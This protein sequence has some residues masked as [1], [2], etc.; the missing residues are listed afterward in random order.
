VAKEKPKARTKPKAASAGSGIERGATEKEPLWWIQPRLRELA[1]PIGDVVLDARNAKTHDANSIDAI[2][3]SLSQFG[4]TSPITVQAEGMVV[5]AGNGR[6]QAAIAL[7]WTHIAAN[8]IGDKAAAWWNAFALAD[9]RS[10]ELAEWNP[11]RVDELLRECDSGSEELQA[12]FEGLAAELNLYEPP[13][14]PKSPTSSEGDGVQPPATPQ[15]YK[16]LVVCKDAAEQ[17]AVLSAAHQQGWNA[18]AF[19]G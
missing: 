14:E 15:E 2:K 6:V 7:G 3:G 10:A 8:V 18:A 16:I 12:L 9:N 5:R 17:L 13:P 11:E 4:Q 1:I 19:A